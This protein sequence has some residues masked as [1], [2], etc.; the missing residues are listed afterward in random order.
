MNRHRCL[1]K[2]NIPTEHPLLY[3]IIK[4]ESLQNQNTKCELK[5]II[6]VGHLENKQEKNEILQVDNNYKSQ[7]KNKLSIA[8]FTIEK[9]YK[10]N[11]QKNMKSISDKEEIKD[12]AK[13][14]N[15]ETISQE[16]ES[17]DIKGKTDK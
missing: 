14:V 10:N 13:P 15:N 2:I 16:T 4:S 1:L 6:S 11:V 9:K 12:F 3:F 5:K 7:T 8:N 17:K